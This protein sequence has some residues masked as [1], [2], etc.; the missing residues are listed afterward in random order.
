MSL[1]Y[2]NDIIVSRKNLLEQL[3]R[4]GY[5]TLN[6]EIVG[7][8]ELRAKIE[9]GGLNF[10]VQT[11]EDVVP[12]RKVYVHYFAQDEP[13]RTRALI[14]LF[15]MYYNPEIGL[16]PATDTLILMADKSSNINPTVYKC[17]ADMW[18][19]N[20]VNIV[21]MSMDRLKFQILDHELV[22]PHRVMRDDEVK[23]V[24]EKFKIQRLSEF[25]KISRFDPVARAIGVRP[26]EVVE[27]MRPS[28]ITLVEPYYRVC[29]NEVLE[30]PKK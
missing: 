9:K 11:E 1:N 30:K 7:A 15:D 25:P 5:D 4:Q 19:V 13:L 24:M 26:D 14:A 3:K 8:D 6:E 22:P 12:A 17:L 20:R 16:D 18:E 21:P 10:M 2:W 28:K 27:I 23:K 29:V